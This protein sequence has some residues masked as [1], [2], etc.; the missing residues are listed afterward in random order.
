MAGK[1][2]NVVP[3]QALILP[4]PPFLS[5]SNSDS[6]SLPSDSNEPSSTTS[7]KPSIIDTHTHVLSTFSEYRRKYPDG[8][9]STIHEFVRGF[10]QP[11]SSSA[12]PTS[13]QRPSVA[14]VVDVYCEAPVVKA[15]RD[16]A[17]SALT[18]EQRV[19][20]WGG[21]QYHFVIGVHPHEARHY[22]DDVELDILEAAT[23]PRCVGMGEM[24][25]DYH[26]DNSPRDIQ[27]AVLV[28]Q[29]KCAVQFGKPLTIHTREADDDIFEILHEHVPKDHKNLN[30]M[31]KT[32]IHIHCFTDTPELAKKLLD[33]FPNLYIG[34]TGV[35]TFATNANTRQVIENLVKASPCTPSTSPS[36]LRVLLETDAP[37]M[38]PGNLSVQTLGLKSGTRL[39][40]SHPGMISWTAQF[41]AEVATAASD[42]TATWSAWDIIRIS[43]ANARRMYGI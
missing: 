11:P 26:Y 3:E 35:V 28:R 33:H 7:Q 9:F 36:P 22:N 38:V 19:G 6:T 15:W 16:V 4:P 24:G 43:E 39:P 10:Y 27:R 41:V 20:D 13:N 8:Q 37:Y 29:L 18:A 25:L 31:K 42:G 17:D 32:K 12:S 2:R 14:A 21:I 5:G 30:V 23:H 34:I 40:F 1:K